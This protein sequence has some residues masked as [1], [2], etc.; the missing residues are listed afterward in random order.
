MQNASLLPRTWDLT[1]YFPSF[2]G[3]EYRQ[4]KA[5]LIDELAAQLTA[6]SALADLSADTRAAW[7]AHFT[8]FED[9]SARLAHLSS[10]LGN[11]NAADTSNEAYKREAAQLA[12]LSA[13]LGKV[14]NELLRA[15][16]AASGADWTAFLAEPA[17]AGAT[18]I[19]S[20]LRTEAKHRMSRPEETLASDLGVDGLEA[21][22][23]LYDNLSGAMSFEMIWPDGRK[24]I[25]PMAQRRALM[26][27]PDRAIR[28]AAFKQGNLT[29]ETHG[30]TC[31]AA[32]NAIAG[33][34]H[35]LYARRGQTQ[36][37]DQP[38]F[39]AAVSAPTIDAMFQAIAANYEIPRAALRL[40]A[41]LQKT[42][43]LAFYDLEA[44][45]PLDPVPSLSWAEAVDLVDR[46]FTAGYPRLGE[47]F[48]S[49]LSQRWIES[50]KRPAK[51]SGA[52]LTG[53]PVTGEQRVYMTYADT[54]HD[55]N[56]L[57]HE[58]GHAWHSHVIKNLRP[59]AQ[60]YPMTLAETAS[61]FAEKVFLD[62]LLQDPQL[63]EAQRG[64]LL[65]QECSRA[66]SY[67][68]N[69]AMRYEFEKEVYTR[70]QQG[71]LS[72]SELNELMVAT[73]RKVY[74]DTIAPGDEDP[75][76]WASKQHFF[77]TEVSFYNYP[78]TFGYL[79]SAT[80]FAELKRTGAGFLPRYEAF[81]R[82]TGVATC[83]DAVKSTLGWDL[84]DPAFWT[85]AVLSTQAPL[86]E[87]AAIVAR[88]TA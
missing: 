50:E 39:D 53:S 15:F 3:P 8:A 68:L 72:V 58:V 5:G 41:R 85:Q 81:L 62:G 78:Y 6:S 64:F 60:D 83:E 82:A 57:A 24:E 38:Y 88:R 35:T 71:E 76:F 73:Q 32:I 49:M 75:W 86:T 87:F 20:R 25:I 2:D 17:L 46:A 10:Y 61:T 1:S 9:L 23:R 45:R 19:A 70:R 14:R 67:L 34:R 59:L 26:A 48:R 16:R 31:A 80:L 51:R 12:T 40:G 37:L 11:L 18:F 33:T 43:A 56:T 22:G 77:I 55:A 30:Q 7:A 65:D 79:L 69:I 52:Y 54:M 28:A 27:S 84:T 47:Y 29:W 66:T 63:T 74:G 44:P 42:P 21:W 4:F 13:S 36:F